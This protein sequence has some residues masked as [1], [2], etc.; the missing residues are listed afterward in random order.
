MHAPVRDG[1]LYAVLMA[2]DHRSALRTSFSYIKSIFDS[3][4]ILRKEVVAVRADTITL[5]NGIRVSAYPCRP[6]SVRG[7]RAVVAVIDELAFFVSTDGRPT[8]VESL[9]AIR[10][11][12][13]TTG[14]RLIILSSPYAPS[15]ALWNLHRQHF[16]QEKSSTL[17]WQ[18]SA[19]CMNPT[20]PRDYLARMREDDPAAAVSEID[21]EFRA[22]LAMLFD[23][24]ALDACVVPGRRELP[25]VDGVDCQAFVDPSGGRR[26][27]FTCAIGHRDGQR[28]VVDVLRGWSAPFNPS[29]V[30]EECAELLKMYR[31]H[32]VVGDRYGGEFPRERF[33]SFGITYELA[34]LDRSRLYLALLPTVNAG[35]VELLDDAELLRELRGLERR[36]GSSGRDRVDHRP[37]AHDDRANAVAG[38]AHSCA[39]AREP[40]DIGVTIGPVSDFGPRASERVD[41]DAQRDAERQADLEVIGAWAAR[42][43]ERKKFTGW[44]PLTSPFLPETKFL[45]ELGYEMVDTDGEEDK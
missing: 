32:T 45:R 19:P 23:P 9:R 22:G 4:E 12:L 17:I 1:E 11:A 21:G 7:L 33:R 43:R 13:S 38:L 6:A 10:P 41:L 18:A 24:D 27:A 44:G 39:S 16:G 30:I 8:D 42:V 14:G 20:L 34:E 28:I 36:R 40:G 31:I 2:Q 15:G 26:D 35:L 37:G 29:G 25:P 3:S 5:H